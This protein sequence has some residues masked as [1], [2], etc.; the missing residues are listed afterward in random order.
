[1]F[2]TPHAAFEIQRRGIAEEDVQQV[3][4]APEQRSAVRAGRD[5][6]QRRVA[7]FGKQYL[8]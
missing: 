6:L 4:H 3:L 1:M 8:L 7:M 5:I 2:I